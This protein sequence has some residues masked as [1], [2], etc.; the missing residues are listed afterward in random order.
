MQYTPPGFHNKRVE[1]FIREVKEKS[2]TVRV[3]L[4]Y[5]LPKKLQFELYAF[6][7]DTINM[8]TTLKPVNTL[9]LSNL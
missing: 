7:V 9:L 8:V 4:S 5:D 6:T 2:N 1:R 3:G